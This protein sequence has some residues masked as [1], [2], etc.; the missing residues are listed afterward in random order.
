MKQEIPV[1]H[2]TAYPAIWVE[3]E[4]EYS[5]RIKELADGCCPVA[6]C[7]LNYEFQGAGKYE[8]VTWTN[9]PEGIPQICLKWV[10][11]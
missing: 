10:G 6:D 5:R 4:E 7:E 11:V 9:R 3:T 2:R 8:P 1:P